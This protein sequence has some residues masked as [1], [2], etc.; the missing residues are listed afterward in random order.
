MISG[1]T[2][3][4][5][6]IIQTA[7]LMCASARTAPK[8][9]GSSTLVGGI[10]FGKE[11]NDLEKKMIKIGE[12]EKKNGDYKKAYRYFRDAIGIH[13]AKA[14]VLIGIK[15]EIKDLDCGLCGASVVSLTDLYI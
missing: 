3:E 9:R 7:K 1:N 13:I 6:V 5:D 4:K 2:A 15:N 14:V 12:K 11:K 8:G 10:I